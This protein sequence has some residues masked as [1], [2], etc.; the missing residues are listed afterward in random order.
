MGWYEQQ[1][2][3][4]AIAWLAR[5]VPDRPEGTVGYAD[6][7]AGVGL[8]G[9]AEVGVGQLALF[10]GDIHRAQSVPWDSVVVNK[11]TGVP[12][13]GYWTINDRRDPMRDGSQVDMDFWT[14]QQQQVWAHVGH[15]NARR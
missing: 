9:P 13:H 5:H 11:A 10:M 14:A 4:D 12:G 8:P 3:D 6:L 15:P 1:H 7:L 2:V